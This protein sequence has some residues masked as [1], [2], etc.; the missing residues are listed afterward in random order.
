MNCTPHTYWNW[1]KKHPLF[2]HICQKPSGCVFANGKNGSTPLKEFNNTN[3]LLL[4]DNFLDDIV[5]PEVFNTWHS[6]GFQNL[7][8]PCHTNVPSGAPRSAYQK[9]LPFFSG[10]AIRFWNPPVFHKLS[11]IRNPQFKCRIRISWILI[12]DP[13]YGFQFFSQHKYLNFKIFISCNVM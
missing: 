2:L 10:M 11:G 12:P 4:M 8:S 3:A 5:Q 6:P 13:G 9:G 1:Q 7:F